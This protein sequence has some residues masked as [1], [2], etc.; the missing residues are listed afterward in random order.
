MCY[1]QLPVLRRLIQEELLLAV[2]KPSWLT[3]LM[4]LLTLLITLLHPL[5]R[6][7]AMCY[8]QLPVLRRI[9]QEEG[10]AT[11]WRGMKP[12][13]LFNAPAAAVSWGTY[14]TMKDML[15]RPDAQQQ[16]QQQQHHH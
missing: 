9:I 2:F 3:P 14:E 16:E 7:S 4:L 11:I 8:L 6:F 1:L 5:R 10:M 12:R 13:V 15:L